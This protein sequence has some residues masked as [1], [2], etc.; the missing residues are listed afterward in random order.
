MDRKGF[1]L[2]ELLVVMA[3]ISILTLVLLPNIVG[4]TRKARKMACSANLRKHLYAAMVTYVNDVNFGGYPSLKG[5]AFWE[6]LRT[7]PSKEDS[8]LSEYRKRHTFYICPLKGGK[9]GDYGMC[10]YRGPNYGVSHGTKGNKPIAADLPDNHGDDTI[11]I[12]YFGGEVEEAKKGASDWDE[13]DKFL[14]E[15]IDK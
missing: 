4:T 7:M 15:K 11:N 5:P 2:I 14:T 10:D 8:V 12:L 3:I 9:Q 6:V 13:A 1:T